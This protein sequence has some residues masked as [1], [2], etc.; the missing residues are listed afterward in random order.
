LRKLQVQLAETNR[1]LEVAN[2]KMKRELALAGVV[3]T[4]F[5][6]RELPGLSGWQLAVTL[7]PAGETSGDFY[8][9]RRLPNGWIGL[10][11]ADVVGKGVG[12]ALYMALSGTL[13]R[14]YAAQTPDQ[15]DRVLDAVNRR[16]LMETRSNQFV[17]VFYG[18]L[19]PIT[20]RLNYSSAGHCPPYLVRDASDGSG[21]RELAGHGVPLGMFAHEAW[22]VA[23]V[24]LD[25]GDVLVVYT[26]GITEARNAQKAFFGEE[27]LLETLRAVRGSRARQI[28]GAVMEAVDDFMGDSVRSDDI[29]LAILIRDL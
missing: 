18:V 26:D 15:P 23:S 2:R 28:E 3:Q 9:V 1:E 24:Q 20:G 21:I 8:D 5:L 6:P 12:A 19:D 10:L 7:K 27:R 16:L 22:P 11:I 14:T 4:S 25:P 29:T 17:T 13:F